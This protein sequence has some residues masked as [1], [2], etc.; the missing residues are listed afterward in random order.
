V[1]LEIEIQDK[2]PLKSNL[3]LAPLHESLLCAAF[4][5]SD[6]PKARSQ[7]PQQDAKL[8][9]D[10]G[11]P[12]NNPSPFEERMAEYSQVDDL[13]DHQA[14]IFKFVAAGT[15]VRSMPQQQFQPQ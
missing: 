11:S 8:Q 7:Q 9:A 10:Y 1:Q 3:V 15:Q 5:A 6:L 13:D 14:D 2:G 12:A 4:P